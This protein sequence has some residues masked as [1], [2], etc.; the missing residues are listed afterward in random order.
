MATTRSNHIEEFQLGP[1]KAPRIF[2]GL[3][4]TSSAAWGT[5]SKP[6][7]FRQFQRHVDCGFTAF[8]MMIFATFLS[9]SMYCMA[10]ANL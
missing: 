10:V 6:K 8:G 4:Q 5:A 2:T 3:W 9:S 1:F 7:I